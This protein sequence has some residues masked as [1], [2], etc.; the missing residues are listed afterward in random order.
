[1]NEPAKKDGIWIKTNHNYQRIML[2]QPYVENTANGVWS[3][4]STP[5]DNFF[6]GV[7]TIYN[8]ILYVFYDGYYY[9]YNG[10]TW[11][12][13]GSCTEINA[14]GAV[15]YNNL[16]YGFGSNYHNDGAFTFDGNTFTRINNLGSSMYWYGQAA[17]VV[18]N[19]K[20]HIF[21]GT[22]YSSREGSNIHYIFNGNTYT[23]LNDIK[24]G[25]NNVYLQFGVVYK[26]QIWA[27]DENK[28]W[29]TYNDDT[30]WTKY[31]SNAFPGGSNSTISNEL[32]V[33]N[34]E[35]HYLTSGGY[36]DFHYKWD[37][38]VWTYLGKMSSKESVKFDCRIMPKFVYNGNIHVIGYDDNKSRNKYDYVYQ[39]SSA[40]YSPN[41]LILYKGNQHNGKYLTAI[42]DTS[43]IIDDGKNNNRFVS[44]F[45]DAVYFADTSF[46]WNA[47]MY[48][49]D[50]TKW[51]KF[52]N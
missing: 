20:I 10:S 33:Y 47:P 27:M 17:H 34:N 3:V 36:G 46:D 40:V 5:P 21:G 22:T 8:G 45:D 15:V 26:G 29:Y 38:S 4:A 37:G 50:G 31:N 9:T 12:R 51:I 39:S 1:M 24:Y 49:G 42:A 19:N 14:G 11:T 44:S 18:Y 35:I 52:K 2:N 41:T 6:Q 16:I 32:L 23:K 28:Y 25:G 7:C 13:C 30:G 43:A 48:Y